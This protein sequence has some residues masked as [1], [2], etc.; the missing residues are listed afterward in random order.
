MGPCFQGKSVKKL[1]ETDQKSEI[2]FRPNG[3]LMEYAVS[4]KNNQYA[5]HYVDK[6]NEISGIG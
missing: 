6:I 5:S 2:L 4:F 1:K 3:F